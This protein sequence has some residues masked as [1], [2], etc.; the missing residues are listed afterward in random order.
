L[1]FACSGAADVG[2]ITD[3]VARKLTQEGVGK[4]FCLAGIGGRVDPILDKTKTAEQTLALDGCPLDC[5]R[6]TLEFADIPNIQH[7]RV[8]DLGMMKGETPVTPDAVGEIAQTARALLSG[9]GRG[10]TK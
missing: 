8:T 2:E 10:G 6:K 4:M 1:I 3:F 9:T 7:L 5:T